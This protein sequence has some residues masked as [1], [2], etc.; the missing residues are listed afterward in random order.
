MRDPANLRIVSL[1]PSATE[2]IH[3]LGLGDALVGRSHECDYPSPVKDLA[4]CTA[5]RLNSARQSGKIDK[6]VKNLVQK[7]LSIYQIETEILEQPQPTHT[8][9]HREVK[10]RKTMMFNEFA[11]YG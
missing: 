6:E 11:I 10:A 2:I 7:A 8:I 9:T 4:I 3:C 5:A 1:L